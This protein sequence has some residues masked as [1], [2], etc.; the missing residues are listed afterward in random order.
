MH[1]LSD[2]DLDRLSRE[3][4]EQFDVDQSPSGWEQVEK[5][6][7]KELPQEKERKRR[8]LWIFFLF[9]LVGGSGL[10]WLL[11]GNR[12]EKQ[13][14]QQLTERVSGL[15]KASNTNSTLPAD[16]S[17][18]NQERTEKNK[19]ESVKERSSI[20]SPADQPLEK[21]E[22]ISNSN[23]P[24]F[25]KEKNS[26][27][28][29]VIK[30]QN[31]LTGRTRKSVPPMLKE[32]DH[33]SPGNKSLAEKKV[34]DVGP[35]SAQGNQTQAD[36]IADENVSDQNSTE[37]TV[38]NK[39]SSQPISPTSKKELTDTVHNSTAATK[40]AIPKQ[41]NNA[42]R[43]WAVGLMLGA[44]HSRINGT[45]DRRV[46]YN[47]GGSISYSLNKRW[48]IST[49]FIVTKKMYSAQAKDFNPPK[50]YWTYYVD[51]KSLSGDCEMWD[52]PLNI[53]YNLSVKP[54]NSWFVNGGISSYIM[55]K[56]S[57]E[58]DYVYNGV[59]SE[60]YW[61]TGSQQNEW[62]KILNISAGYE[63]NLNKSWSLQAEPF[64]KLPLTGVGFGK[65]DLASYGIMLGVKYKPVFIKRKTTIA[66]KNP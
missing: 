54:S 24:L 59:P 53:R 46:G 29:A 12:S 43:K 65:M 3:A 27:G 15:D 28:S 39:D 41:D 60:G 56:Q 8:F 30:K 4:S 62:F 61:K 64:V 55:R 32:S 20:T 66:S 40:K 45:G 10:L 48:V 21:T 26:I 58:Y 9:F 19:Q 51:L 34:P 7:N 35:D 6:L 63:R 23:T 31:Q 25:N 2:K 57:Y 50:H 47:Y 36:E 18:G 14:A 42:Q 5:R 16:E 22:S 37:Q 49:G 13:S 44:D 52:I 17:T 33:L 38:N 11:A 1:P